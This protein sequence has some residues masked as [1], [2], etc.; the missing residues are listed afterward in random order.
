MLFLEQSQQNQ[1]SLLL[2]KMFQGHLSREENTFYEAIYCNNRK[3]AFLFLTNY[4]R[5]FPTPIYYT[6]RTRPL[7]VPI[8]SVIFKFSFT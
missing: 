4:F 6:I 7:E 8:F 3:N 1:G 5:T 2:L